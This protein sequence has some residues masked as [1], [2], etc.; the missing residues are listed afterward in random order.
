MNTKNVGNS[1]KWAL[2]WPA[3]V[4]RIPK[5]NP[6]PRTILFVALTAAIG[7]ILAFFSTPNLV[8]ILIVYGMCALLH[9]LGDLL[10]DESF[11]RYLNVME[12]VFAFAFGC[13]LISVIIMFF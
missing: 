8:A 9:I 7:G 5:E 3:V 13:V 1:L 12:G 4:L 10:S 6:Q 2:I 11:G